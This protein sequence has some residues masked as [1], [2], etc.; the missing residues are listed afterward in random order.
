MNFVRAR[1]HLELFN[2]RQLLLLSQ[3]AKTAVRAH[4]DLYR[5]Q[6]SFGQYEVWELTGED[7][8]YVVP[9]AYEP[10]FYTSQDW[11]NDAYR[12]FTYGQT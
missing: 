6:H 8:R 1:R 5:L 3:E 12:W 7:F 4:P 10:I 9:L 2:A 11:K